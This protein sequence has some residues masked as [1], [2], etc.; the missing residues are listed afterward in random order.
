[1]R[2]VR[3][4]TLIQG[5]NELIQFP[6]DCLQR[7]Q[8]NNPLYCTCAVSTHFEERKFWSGA[9]IQAIFLSYVLLSNKA[10]SQKKKDWR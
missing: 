4:S 3:V 9:K 8:G 5:N 2:Q 1:M 7:K 6:V 10:I